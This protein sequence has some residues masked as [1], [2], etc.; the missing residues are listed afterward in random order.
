MCRHSDEISFG[1]EIGDADEPMVLARNLRNPRIR[2]P[3]VS[4]GDDERYILNVIG[5]EAAP[6]DRETRLAFTHRL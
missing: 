6:L 3:V 1:G 4:C 5:L 2:C